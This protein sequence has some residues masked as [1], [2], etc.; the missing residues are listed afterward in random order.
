MNFVINFEIGFLA[1][2]VFAC[3][4]FIFYLLKTVHKIES[5]LDRHMG[6]IDKLF[7]I[8]IDLEDRINKK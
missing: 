3:G 1:G 2:S 8:I 7:K 4:I 5:R 6:Y